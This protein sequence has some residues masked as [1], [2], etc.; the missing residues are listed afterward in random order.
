MRCGYGL[1]QDPKHHKD[2]QSERLNHLYK[3]K[4]TKLFWWLA[5]G[6][7]RLWGDNVFF[8]RIPKY[9]AASP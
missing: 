3:T 6:F 1:V 8:D 5:Q 7:Q 9:K 2:N 4:Y